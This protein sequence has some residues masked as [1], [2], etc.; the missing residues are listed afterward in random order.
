MRVVTWFRTDD[1]FPEHVKVDALEAAAGRGRCTPPRAPSGTTSAATAPGDAPTG[2]F[3]ASAP[4]ASAAAPAEVV[5]QALAA[6][7]ASGLIRADG[8]DAYRFH[9]WDDYQPTKAELDHESA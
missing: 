1:D 4:T 8:S 5:D 3:T 9:D 7:V 6:F 2:S